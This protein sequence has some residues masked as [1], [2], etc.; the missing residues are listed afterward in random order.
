MVENRRMILG[1]VF[2]IGVV[3]ILLL[4]SPSS[5]TFEMPDSKLTFISIITIAILGSFGHCIGMCGGIVVAYSSTKID[6]KW[7]KTKQATAHLLY[8]FGRVVTYVLFGVIFGYIGSIATISNGA[9]SIMWFVIGVIMV[10]MGFSLMGKIKFM[11]TIEHSLMQSNWYQKNFKALIRSNTLGSFFL[12]GVLNGLL[13]CGFVYFFVIAAAATADPFQ[14]AIVMFIFGLSTIPAL[15]SIGFFIGLSKQTGFRNVMIKLAAIFVILYGIF[16]IYKSYMFYTT[17][18]SPVK[19][20]IMKH[21]KS[22]QKDVNIKVE[23]HP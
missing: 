4:L 7:L 9:L 22:I 18:K 20:A 21:T 5:G 1:S 16:S 15:F 11:T 10:I 23:H 14:G 6:D 19:H 12:L 17:N 2:L 8:S 3:V 13:P